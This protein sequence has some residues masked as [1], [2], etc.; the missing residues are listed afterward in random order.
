MREDTKISRKYKKR[1]SGFTSMQSYYFDKR[2]IIYI[3]ILLDIYFF[4]KFT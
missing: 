1:K 3:A 4:V 2:F